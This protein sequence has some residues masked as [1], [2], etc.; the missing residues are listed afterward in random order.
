MERPTRIFSAVPENSTLL[1]L[2]SLLLRFVVLLSTL[3][4]GVVLA[5]NSLPFE[6][7]NPKNQKWSPEQAEKIYQSACDL[8]ARTI[9]PSNPPRLH[10][11]FV[12]TLGAE[13]DEYFRE[14]HTNAIHLKTWDPS[15]FA[16]AVVLGAVRE[17]LRTEDLMKVAQQSLAL[18]DATVSAK[19][20]KA[21]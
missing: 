12:L 7:S 21:R 17:V 10:P 4:T 6:V 9:N 3:M 18:A 19:E 16:E 15:K 13:H 1:A 2:G 14:G 11:R 8:L 5:Q 20:L